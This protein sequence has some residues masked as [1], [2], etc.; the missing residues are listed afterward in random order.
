MDDSPSSMIER[1][2]ETG[3]STHRTHQYLVH[4][5]ALAFHVVQMALA[6]PHCI[7]SKAWHSGHLNA[8]M[9]GFHKE[10]FVPSPLVS[11][12]GYALPVLY[13]YPYLYPPSAP[14]RYIT[15]GAVYRYRSCSCSCPSSFD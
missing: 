11:C 14:Y 4:P 6:C 8:Q 15:I 7:L 9:V 12:G 13:L 1:K 3:E 2:E 5:A 10:G